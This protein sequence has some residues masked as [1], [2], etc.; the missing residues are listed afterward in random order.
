MSKKPVFLEDDELTRRLPAT[1]AVDWCRDAVLAAH[2]G[3]L[4][5]PPR[6]HT[7]LGEGRFAFTAGRLAG[8]W[9]GYRAYDTF[10]TPTDQQVV[11]VH[12]DLSGQVEGIAVST[13]LGPI[14]TGAICGVAADA[15]A[16]PDAR[17]AAIIGCGPQAWM[18][19]WALNAVR[20]L[21]RVTVHCRTEETRERFAANASERYGIDVTA[22][23]TAEAAVSNAQIV[24]LATN[25]GTPVV[26]TAAISETA[27]VAT[28]GPKQVG[29]AEFDDTLAR[30][31]PQIVT[32]S[33]PQLHAYEP[34][35]VLLESEPPPPITALGAI[36]AGEVEPRPGALFCS[37]GLAGTEAYLIAK[38][39]AL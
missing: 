10:P 24:I 15:L 38:L 34:S 16:A 17:T 35:F 13:D 2:D 37:V 22:S 23:A 9:Y 39:L 8:S 33:L 6:A 4:L 5:T 11:V 31:S 26:D 14:R 36:L 20:D 18:Q 21:N 19:L 30:R 29:R 7:D 25:S 32:D 27:Y 1:T 12:S 28:L 3:D